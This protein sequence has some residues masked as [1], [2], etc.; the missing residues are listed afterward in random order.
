MIRTDDDLK[1]VQAE[2]AD[3]FERVFETSSLMNLDA[4]RDRA[5]AENMSEAYPVDSRR[6]S[7]KNR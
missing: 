4:L 5:I 2:I 7:T 6:T 1:E 3:L